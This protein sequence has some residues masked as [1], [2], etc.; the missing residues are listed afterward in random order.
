M[1]GGGGGFAECVCSTLI[2]RLHLSLE[3]MNTLV[4]LLSCEKRS[5]FSQPSRFAGGGDAGDADTAVLDCCC[6][7]LLL[8]L[9]LYVIDAAAICY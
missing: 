5:L 9:I 2:S 7:M 3:R 6:C 1:C 8:L 4:V